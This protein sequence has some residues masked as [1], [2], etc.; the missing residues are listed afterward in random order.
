MSEVALRE[1]L[2]EIGGKWR[3]DDERWCAEGGSGGAFSKF[4]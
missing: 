3:N 4:L 2:R 1:F